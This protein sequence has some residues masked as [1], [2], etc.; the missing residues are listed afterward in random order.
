[1]IELTFAARRAATLPF[2]GSGNLVQ[3]MIGG[4][5]KRALS[6]TNRSPRVNSPSS[7]H[8]IAWHQ[9]RHSA[10]RRQL[11]IIPLTSLQSARPDQ[12]VSVDVKGARTKDD[13][14]VSTRCYVLFSSLY[15]STAGNLP[16]QVASGVIRRTLHAFAS[17]LQSDDLRGRESEMEVHVAR[18]L[19][20]SGLL[21]KEVA[22][23]YLKL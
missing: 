2:Y 4:C 1:M 14:D 19:M 7:R 9:T 10:P 15:P 5:F 17:G 23:R 11:F 3:A 12:T 13:K 8:R 16:Q 22:I 6:S 21:V 18:A 20:H